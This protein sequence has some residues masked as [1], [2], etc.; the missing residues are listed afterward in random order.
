L[1]LCSKRNW[2]LTFFF[3]LNK[4][5][6]QTWIDWEHDQLAEIDQEQANFLEAAKRPNDKGEMTIN[7]EILIA[8]LALSSGRKSGK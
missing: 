2:S 8:L 7:A 1:S 3:G 5:E 4:N 6:Q